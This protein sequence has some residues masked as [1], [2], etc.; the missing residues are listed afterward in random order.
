VLDPTFVTTEK[1]TYLVA[2][3][4]FGHSIAALQVDYDAGRGHLPRGN[5]MAAYLIIDRDELTDAD[6]A[7]VGSV[8]PVEGEQ[9]RRLDSARL[10]SP[11]ARRGEN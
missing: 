5:V 2:L 11:R 3:H 8:R 7:Y 4:E 6:F 10:T 9:Q 1:L